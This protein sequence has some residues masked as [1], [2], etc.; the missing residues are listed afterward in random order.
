MNRAT[1]VLALTMF[2]AVVLALTACSNYQFGQRRF[3]TRLQPSPEQI[4]SDQMKTGDDRSVTFTQG[5][6]EITLRP[7]THEMLD[8]QFASYAASR[9]GFYQ[10]PVFTPTNPYTYNHWSPPESEQPPERFAVF[11]LKVKNY[12]F[13]KVYV[14]PRTIHMTSSNGR[15]YDVLDLPILIEYYQT[16]AIGYAGNHYQYFE[17]RTDL[18]RRT[19][20]QDEFV[21][22][23]WEKEGYIV[24]PPLDRDVESITVN[25]EEV[26]LRFDFRDEAVEIV[27]VPFKFERET[28]MARK[29]RAEVTD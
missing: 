15:R 2:F 14:N 7:F 26:A 21:F 5:R 1:V 17:E 16:Y 6:L 18:L 22:S 13:P 19:L 9:D 27:N 24:F 23:G 20:F 29:P 25:L 4:R 8:R 3:A 10:N 28:Y 12:E 11:L